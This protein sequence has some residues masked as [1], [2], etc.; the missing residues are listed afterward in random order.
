M[1]KKENEKRKRKS[2]KKTLSFFSVSPPALSLSPSLFLPCRSTPSFFEKPFGLD[3]DSTRNGGQ[4]L[5]QS[6]TLSG[7]KIGHAVLGRDTR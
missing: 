1:R 7:E 5:A 3:F 4:A 6:R 2:K